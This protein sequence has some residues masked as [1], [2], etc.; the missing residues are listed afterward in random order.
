VSV[1]VV[2]QGRLWAGTASGLRT[3]DDGA[4]TWANDVNGLPAGTAVTA[5]VIS[6]SILVVDT[7]GG[8]WVTRFQ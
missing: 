3:S 4:L 8:P 5:L 1:F 7:P 6:G 2:D